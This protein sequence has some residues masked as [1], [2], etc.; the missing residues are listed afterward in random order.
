VDPRRYFGQVTF[1]GGYAQAW[2]ALKNG[3]VDVTVIAGDVPE[4][5]YRDVLAAT[6][7]LA[8]Q[9]P[10]PSH[11]VLFGSNLAEPRR[12]QFK[13]ALLELGS[14]AHRPLMRKFIS[15]IFVR[16]QET[17]AEA[18]LATLASSLDATGLRFTESLR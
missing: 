8:E 16:F 11:A 7:I 9:G 5:L 6:T 10:I 17:T 2:E 3:Q 15:G 18:H 12:A 13:A 4:A 1:A 14:D